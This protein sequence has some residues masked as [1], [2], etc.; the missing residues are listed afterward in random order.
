MHAKKT[1][2][3]LAIS[4]AAP[5][6]GNKCSEIVMHTLAHSH[7]GHSMPNQRRIVRTPLRF[8]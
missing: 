3:H 1:L 2:A 6:H 4:R 7:M 5:V 8:C